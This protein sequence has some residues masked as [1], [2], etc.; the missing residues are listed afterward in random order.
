MACTTVYVTAVAMAT[1]Q[2]WYNSVTQHVRNLYTIKSIT[3]HVE[4]RN[5]P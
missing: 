1:A 3:L 4:S 5:K 2:T